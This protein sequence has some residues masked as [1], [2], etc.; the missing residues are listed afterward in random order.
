LKRAVALACAALAGACAPAG[1]PMSDWERNNRELLAPNQPAAAI[2]PPAYPRDQNL[3]EF[4]QS[5]VATM[6]YYIDAASITTLYKEGEVRYTLVARSPSGAKNVS[7]E[8]I[9]CTG[10]QYR[11]IATGN[12]DST[13]NTRAGEWRDIERRSSLEAQSTLKRQFFCPHN[14]PIQSSAEGVDALRRGAHPLVYVEQQNRG[15]GR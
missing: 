15:G 12:N 8:G 11:V 6:R 4:Y 2:K 9:R 14:D 1:A 5:P 10:N 7:F 3:I 13:W